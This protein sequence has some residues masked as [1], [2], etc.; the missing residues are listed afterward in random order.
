MCVR[1]CESYPFLTR[2]SIFTID[3]SYPPHCLKRRLA[4]VLVTTFPVLEQEIP[5]C[6]IKW[7]IL[8]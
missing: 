4:E 5:D 8:F 1:V 6:D 3:F 7:V 2:D